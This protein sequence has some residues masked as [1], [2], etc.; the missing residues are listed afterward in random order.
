MQHS[1]KS[2]LRIEARLRRSQGAYR[3]LHAVE[4]L[5]NTGFKDPNSVQQSISRL[6]T[7]YPSQVA[8]TSGMDQ[9]SFKDGEIKLSSPYK[10]NSAGDPITFLLAM[11][12]ADLVV[13]FDDLAGA[14]LANKKI[15]CDATPGGKAVLLNKRF[16]GDQKWAAKGVIELISIRNAIVH[17]K[18]VWNEKALTELAAADIN[19]LPKAGTRLLVGIDDLFRY[20]RAVRTTLNL[21]KDLP[22]GES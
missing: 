4:K 20:R 2:A 21:I 11:L 3:L 19:E 14:Q 18:A 17:N 16:L 5:K 8:F 6:V 1:Q 22:A 15:S 12:I 10:Q 9:K 13:L 7:Q